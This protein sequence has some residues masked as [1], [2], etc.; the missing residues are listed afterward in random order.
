[1]GELCLSWPS[2]YQKGFSKLDIQAVTKYFQP[3][4][5]PISHDV[6]SHPGPPWATLGTMENGFITVFFIGLSLGFICI[7]HLVLCFGSL[8]VVQGWPRRIL[9]VRSDYHVFR[10]L[11]HCPAASIVRHPL[12]SIGLHWPPLGSIGLH[13]P[14]TSICPAVSIGLHCLHWPSLASIGLHWPP[15]AFIGLH[16]PASSICPAASQ[17]S[18][19]IHS[20]ESLNEQFL[21]GFSFNVN[22]SQLTYSH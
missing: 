9:L 2:C 11:A 22:V 21:I 13:C 5:V 1:M 12:A 4:L 10:N 18:H 20:L 6:Y 8:Q 3:M 7:K 17:L 16:C 15:L 14:A 19:F